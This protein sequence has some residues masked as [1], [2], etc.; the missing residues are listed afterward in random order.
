MSNDSTQPSNDR[1]DSPGF[2]CWKWIF[3][4]MI[5]GAAVAIGYLMLV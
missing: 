1:D 4:G 5:A 3:L 2:G